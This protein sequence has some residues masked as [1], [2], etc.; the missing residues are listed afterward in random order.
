MPL[1][2]RASQTLE[3]MNDKS[4][5]HAAPDFPSQQILAHWNVLPR[6]ALGAFWRPTNSYPETLTM[7]GYNFAMDRLVTW[8]I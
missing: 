1:H 6:M 2:E 7:N 5:R 8:N 4:I 3:G